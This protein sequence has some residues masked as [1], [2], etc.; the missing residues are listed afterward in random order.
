MQKFY[1]DVVLN[2]QISVIDGETKIKDLIKKASV[3]SGFDITLK[4]F[5]IIKL[6]DGIEIENTN[7][8]EEVA[9]TVNKN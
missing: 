2:E 4:G 3:D 1:Q 5:K 8:A 6:G 7:F 9:A